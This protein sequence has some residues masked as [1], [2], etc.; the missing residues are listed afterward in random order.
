MVEALNCPVCFEQYTDIKKPLILPCGHTT[1]KTCLEILQ[2]KSIIK[3]PFCQKE[4]IADFTKFHVNYALMNNDSPTKGSQS[5]IKIGDLLE[6][7]TGLQKEIQYLESIE[8]KITDF[9]EESFGVNKKCK[10]DINYALDTIIN[11]LQAL[12]G[13]FNNKVEENIRNNNKSE[14]KAKHE[15]RSQYQQRKTLLGK[16]YD[17]QRA[18][19]AP[20]TST[21]VEFNALPDLQAIE[22]KFQKCEFNATI[23][24]DV[25]PVAESINQNLSIK[26]EEHLWNPPEKKIH[27]SPYDLKY[28]SQSKNPSEID[29]ESEI[30]ISD[31]RRQNRGRRGWRRGGRRGRNRRDFQSSRGN[32]SESDESFNDPHI[33]N[34]YFE[35]K[36]QLENNYNNPQRNIEQNNF[37]SIDRR[38]G[39]NFN[40]NNPGRR[41]QGRRGGHYGH[42]GIDED[43][44]E[45]DDH[46]G[47]VRG[48]HHQ[49][50]GNQVPRNARFGRAIRN[51]GEN[52]GGHII[53]NQ[54]HTDEC[55]WFID[56][57]GTLKPLPKFV[58]MQINEKKNQFDVIKI[59]KNGSVVNIAELTKMKYYTL[60]ENQNRVK[61]QSHNLIYIPPNSNL[62][63]I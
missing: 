30:S 18:N 24:F 14:A 39:R 43:M 59:F 6:I 40:N 19:K 1:C 55:N 37:F 63:D 46:G 5:Q 38:G 50:E 58:L 31:N 15:V 32:S 44:V 51:R 49:E 12:K 4:F 52:R 36:D 48:M 7:S 11:T 33:N 9:H 41:N 21:V 22:L 54:A 2:K 8:K 3:C 26:I 62:N 17:S 57:N 60:D 47:P 10:E 35:H 34:D 56:V 23:N 16:F 61:G 29:T 28:K 25:S 13:Q 27:D 20:D 45:R 42:E 53:N